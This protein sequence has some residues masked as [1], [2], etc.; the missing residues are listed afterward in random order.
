MLIK[1]SDEFQLLLDKLYAGPLT[2]VFDLET[3][4][5]NSFKQDRLIGVAL[6]I[7][8]ENKNPDESFY[9]PFRHLDGDNLPI[10]DLRKLAPFF[11][12]PNRTL[13]GYN[14]KFDVHFTEAEDMFVH[15]QLID[16][17]LAAHLANENEM[18]FA[19]KHLGNKYISDD[20]SQSETE[21]LQKL[22]NK[23][24]KKDGMCF[25]PPEDVAP[26]AE[27][28]VKLTWQMFKF[29]EKE[30]D[31]QKLLPLWNEANRYLK[32]IVVMERNGVLVDI[33]GCKSS[34]KHATS[35]KA[36]IYE[37]MKEIV[38]HDFNPDSVPQLRKILGQKHTDKKA[39]MTSNHPVAK[40]LVESRSWGKAANTFYGAFL[41]LVDKNC[42]IHPSLNPIGTVSSRLSCRNPNLQALPKKTNT[43]HIRDLII[44]PPGYVLMSWD[45][46]QAELRI[47]AH[48]TKDPF[49]IDAFKYEKDIHQETASVLNI[50]RD[51]AKRIN[52]GVVYGVGPVA[53]AK[54]LEISRGK[55]KEYLDRYNQ[56]IPGVRKLYNVA[57]RLATRDRKIQ[58]WTGRIRH[59]QQ[60]DETYKAM[61]NLIQGAVAE[62]M[63]IAIT[64]LDELL[65][66]TLAKAI[67]QVHDEIL[68]EIPESQING[69]S[70]VIKWAMETFNFD[71]P[72]VAEGKFGKTWGDMQPVTVNINQTQKEG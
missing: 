29:Y 43:H 45:W 14:I 56:H 12:D 15:N 60:E 21:L 3:T 34:L 52:F 71:V 24:L 7:P 8:G 23:K 53:L 48:Y 42:R 44:A 55:A 26:Y 2:T 37:K 17:M 57:E 72:I 69:W 39:L 61:S 4:G 1:N 35:R 47:L 30:L 31:K 11:A 16:V 36:E 18:S 20:S 9:I 49:L 27:Q 38:G 63:R 28:D 19:L 46:S 62:M 33:K 50:P 59:Y 41:E 68:F 70:E 32:S 66:G 6:L 54:E 10:T 22:K 5:L 64:R 65:T 40:L 58:L 51:M 13:I 25:L 67:L